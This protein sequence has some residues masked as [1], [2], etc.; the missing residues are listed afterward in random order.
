MIH[1]WQLRPVLRGPSKEVLC[2][3]Y[4][5]P[6]EVSDLSLEEQPFFKFHCLHERGMVHIWSGLDET[7]VNWEL[8]RVD[9]GALDQA[10]E[11]LEEWC[12]GS[13]VL[14]YRYGGLRVEKYPN[15]RSA[16]SRILR[17]AAYQNV[18]VGEKAIIHEAGDIQ[19]CSHF[20]R[21]G[22][23]LAD[24]SN[25]LSDLIAL[26]PYL[27]VYTQSEENGELVRLHA[28]ELSAAAQFYGADWQRQTGARYS[29]DDAGED[30]SSAVSVNYARALNGQIVI[31]HIYALTFSDVEGGVWAPYQRLLFRTQLRNGRSALACLSD[32]TDRLAFPLLPSPV[33]DLVH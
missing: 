15:A 10:C 17:L 16:T 6:V 21:R 27:L 28:G 5:D 9:A 29:W 12:N 20:I 13:V 1:E 18:A 22:F 23:Q 33:V 19:D 4:G 24:Q 14:R 2:S 7:C 3:G 11:W 25:Q 8:P 26:M 31:D 32:L 30:Y